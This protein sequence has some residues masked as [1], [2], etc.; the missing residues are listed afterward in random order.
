MGAFQFPRLPTF[1]IISMVS[2][3]KRPPQRSN[4]RTAGA[5]FQFLDNTVIFDL[6]AVRS[7]VR[8][9]RTNFGAFPYERESSSAD[10]FVPRPYSAGVI[11]ACAS[12]AARVAVI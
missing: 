4:V 1:A 5:S 12:A 10:A 2:F 11:S 6:G 3:P 7:N 8:F 9:S